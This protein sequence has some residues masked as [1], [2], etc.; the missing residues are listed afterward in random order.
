MGRMVAAAC[1]YSVPFMAASTTKRCVFRAWADRCSIPIAFRFWKGGQGFAL[2][3]RAGTPLP[4][5]NRTVLFLL[6]AVQLFQGRTLSY[7]ALDVEQI[8]YVYEGLLDRTV[9][10][11][12]EV[13][14]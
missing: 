9:V 5:D 10:R 11:A 6:E 14:T 2:E 3:D 12:A 13:D 4:I 8:G 7:M 1:R